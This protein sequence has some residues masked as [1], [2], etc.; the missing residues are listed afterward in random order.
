[1]STLRQRGK[2]P[3]CDLESLKKPA[4][5]LFS[6]ICHSLQAPT[7]RL[8]F[9]ALRFVT[10]GSHMQLLFLPL[11]VDHT[12]NRIYHNLNGFRPCKFRVCNISCH[13]RNFFFG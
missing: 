4:T 11:P 10:Y 3:W 8:I 5:I 13:C 7:C 2:Y 9:M 12:I 1:M 6:Q